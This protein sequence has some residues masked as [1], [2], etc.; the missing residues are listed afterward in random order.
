MQDGDCTFQGKTRNSFPVAQGQCAGTYNLRIDQPGSIKAAAAAVV[1]HLCARTE[2]TRTTIFEHNQRKWNPV[3]EPKVIHS[4][5]E[6]SISGSNAGI[7]T[8]LMTER[9]FIK[10]ANGPVAQ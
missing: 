10:I 7:I 2:R 3:I 8:L 4:E 6:N 1:S 9:N 5:S